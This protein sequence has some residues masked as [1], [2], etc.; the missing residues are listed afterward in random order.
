M[1]EM[2]VAVFDNDDAAEEG[3]NALKKLHQEGGISVYGWALVVKNLDGA[4]SVKQRSGELLAG[5]GVGL[6]MGGIV[7]L[8]GGPVGAAVGGAIGSYV[9]LLADWARHG[10]DLQFLDDVSKTM[11]RGKAAVLAEIE[12]TWVSPIELR[13]KEQGGMVFRRFR[14]EM[15]DDQLLQE[16]R[17]LQKSLETLEDELDRT[18][19]PNQEALR[20]NMFDVKQQLRT[21]QVRA[22]AAIDL[23]KAETES[24]LKVLRAQAETAGKE[25]KARIDRRI[26]DAQAD[27]EMRAQKIRQASAM[28]KEALGPQDDFGEPSVTG[29]R[30][31]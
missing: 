12:E 23:K 29:F 19:G 9:G 22:K 18:S 5:T 11:A 21:I 13:L 14:T 24:K 28:A 4:V 10:I 31:N 8:L 26:S 17:A 7:G 2:L 15:I 6:L 27:F 25:A 16:Q 30:L 20:K 1:N 3:L